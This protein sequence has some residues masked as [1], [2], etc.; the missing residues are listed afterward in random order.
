MLTFV[1]NKFFNSFKKMKKEHREIINLI[2]H[3]LEQYPDQRFGQAIFNLGINEFTNKN[4]PEKDDYKIRDIH[5][6][7]DI[8]IIERIKSQLEWFEKQKRNL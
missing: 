6:D 3:Y 2:S 1:E 7:Q 8:T 4:Q 5:S